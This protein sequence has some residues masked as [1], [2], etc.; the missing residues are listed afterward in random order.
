MTGSPLPA[1]SGTAPTDLR[2][3][4]ECAALPSPFAGTPIYR[5]LSVLDPDD[6]QDRVLELIGETQI[7]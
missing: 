1:D 6:E 2:L 3:P 4:A 7:P 5:D